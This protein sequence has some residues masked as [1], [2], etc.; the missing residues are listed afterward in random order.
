MPANSGLW[1]DTRVVATGQ[2]NYTL[3]TYN[4]AGVNSRV[5]TLTCTSVHT[6]AGY[7]YFY[8][9]PTVPFAGVPFFIG[10]WISEGLDKLVAVIAL[11]FSFVTPFNFSLLGY[12][13]LA[14]PALAV[15]FV[16]LMYGMAYLFIGIMFYSMVSALRGLLG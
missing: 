12:N 8:G 15:V 16:V 4:Y 5:N 11:G 13:L 6:I 14:M 3:G 2:L 1:N 10:D 7:D 9:A